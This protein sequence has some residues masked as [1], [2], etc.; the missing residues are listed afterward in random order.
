MCLVSPHS[1][2]PSGTT[3]KGKCCFLWGAGEV[4]AKLV[5]CK[6][7]AAEDHLCYHLPLKETKTEKTE[8]RNGEGK[9]K[10]G[11][12]V[13]ANVFGHVRLRKLNHSL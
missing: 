7:G 10:P 3:G 1:Y 11:D 8:L 5:G 6:C 4:V 9:P 12:M 2:T 13:R